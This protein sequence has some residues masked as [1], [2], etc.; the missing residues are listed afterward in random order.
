MAMTAFY[1]IVIICCN[2]IKY[3]A[4]PKINTSKYQHH[5]RTQ[6]ALHFQN[7]QA[8]CSDVF[9]L[10]VTE[11]LSQDTLSLK[12]LSIISPILAM[13]NC[14]LNKFPL[15][16]VVVMIRP[17][18]FPVALGPSAGHSLLIL[19]VSKSHNGAPQSVRLLWSNDQLVAETST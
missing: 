13:C 4:N 17:Y 18:F 15:C 7:L 6:N 11:I 16:L 3:W 1:I 19:G 12:M 2:L 8:C 14:N 5:Q 9:F 10:H